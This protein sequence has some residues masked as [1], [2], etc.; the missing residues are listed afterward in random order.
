VIVPAPAPEVVTVNLRFTLE[1]VT[2]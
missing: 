2:P 1:L